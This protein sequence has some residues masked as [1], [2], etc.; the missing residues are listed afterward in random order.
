M[1]DTRM[2]KGRFVL[3]VTYVEPN[4]DYVPPP[5]FEPYE[6][7]R[8]DTRTAPQMHYETQAVLSAELTPMQ[9]EALKYETLKVW[10]AA[11]KAPL[12]MD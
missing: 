10:Q 5:E 1:S 11:M 12:V 2:S 4:P 6:Y 3:T 7:H 9:F 8:K